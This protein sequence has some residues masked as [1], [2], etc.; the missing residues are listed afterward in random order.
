MAGLH[1]ELLGGFAARLSS[2]EPVVVSGRKKQALLTYLAINAGQRQSREK[3]V[4]LL[5]GDRGESQGRSSLRQALFALRQDLS[6]IDPKPLAFDRDAVALN[7][8]AVST[9]VAKLVWLVKFASPADLALAIGQFEGELLDGVVVGD[10][11]FGDWL[12]AERGRLREMVIGALD[13]LLPCLS[14]AEAVIS[15]CRLVALDPLR[16]SSHRALMQA[17]AAQAQFEPAIRQYY[18]CRNLLWRELQIRPSKRTEN[19][20]SEISSTRHQGFT[21]AGKW[22]T[23]ANS[24]PPPTASKP[25]SP[26]ER[27]STPAYA[28]GALLVGTPTVAV[29]PF[30]CMSLDP[31]ETSFCHGLTEDIVTG[32]SRFHDQ[33]IVTSNLSFPVSDNYAGQ[34][35][36]RI[37]TRYQMRGSVR[38]SGASIRIIVQLINEVSGNYV[39]SDC[40]DRG[41]HDI[42][43]IQD[44]LVQ[45]IVTKAVGQLEV[46]EAGR[47]RRLQTEDMAA[48]DCLLRGLEYRRST[49]QE[50]TSRAIYWF[51][52]A[53][54]KDP[55]YAAALAR[56]AGA[57]AAASMFQRSKQ[58]AAE[59]LDEAQCL[60]ARAVVLDPN[61]SLTHA[62]RAYV[63]LCGLGHAR[64]SHAV[65]AEE[66]D[67]ALRLNPNEPDL[68]VRRAL[69]YTYSGKATAA[70]RLIEKAEQ[71]IP[72]IPNWYLSS[73]GFALFEL[74]RYPE[75]AAALEQVT[76]PA[77]W[78]HYYLAACYANMGRRSEAQSQI[79]KTIERFPDLTL[80][81]LGP[82]TWFTEPDELEHL[83][84]SLSQAGMPS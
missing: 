32:L 61:D 4:N 46:A 64:G 1:L 3:L 63:H 55:N 51:E 52:K 11:A 41:V 50:E 77:H 20:Y 53:Q 7:A 67:K 56:L 36:E 19:L 60:A 38:R 8:S 17:Y 59:L 47:A 13:R 45:T 78:D 35:D 58:R 24:G 49:S 42:L 21:V 12:T 62:E 2:G 71:L 25:D 29:L 43:P 28:A 79:T 66:M 80:S 83:L 15:A 44:E 57:K 34:P 27:I 16:E 76:S 72:S 68:M 37:G 48:Y 9:D 10:A 18:I 26:F 82:R 39:W 31:R 14:G 65:A 73:R 75:A 54:E 70:L 23:P 5:W 69:Q 6:K 84:G 22:P 40:F 30:T 74:R 81:Y 33:C